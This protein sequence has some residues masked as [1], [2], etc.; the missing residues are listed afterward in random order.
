MTAQRFWPPAS[1]T[2]TRP[3]PGSLRTMR[4]VGLSVVIL[5]VVAR[6][7]KEVTPPKS[8]RGA[9]RAGGTRAGASGQGACLGPRRGRRGR[10]AGG[11]TEAGPLPGSGC[12][13]RGR[14]CPPSERTNLQ[15]QHVGWGRGAASGQ[16]CGLGYRGWAR[17]RAAGTAAQERACYSPDRSAVPARSESKPVGYEVMSGSSVEGVESSAF[18]AAGAAQRRRLGRRRAKVAG[19]LGEG[20]HWV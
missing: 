16:A 6:P 17:R 18:M 15:V 19:A 10:P 7:L 2:S 5:T 14:R 1:T 8:L 12:A 13:C 3:A 11:L 9:G 4:T 20:G